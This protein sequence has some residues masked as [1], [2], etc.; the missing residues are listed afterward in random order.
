IASILTACP[1]RKIYGYV[2]IVSTL[3]ITGFLAFSVWV[4][5]MFATGLPQLGQSFFTAASIMI[6]IPTAVQMF[7]WIAT[8]WTGRLRMSTPVLY[9]IGFFFVFAIG[10]VTGIMVAE[11]PLNWQLHD[12]FFIVDHLHYVLIGGSGSPPF[13]A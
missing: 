12:T 7:C 11:V 1:G 6:T 4:H 9:V 8:I 13:G 3:V 2:A 10:G 5:P